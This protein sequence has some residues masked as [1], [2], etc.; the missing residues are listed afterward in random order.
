SLG[1]VTLATA[2]PQK[3]PQ[4]EAQLRALFKKWDLNNDGFLDREELA[5]HFRGPQAV[6]PAGG[7]YDDKG[8][9]TPLYHQ[10]RTK[11]PDLM[12]L[13]PLDKDLD[14]RVSWPEFEQYGLKYANALKQ[15][16]QAQQGLLQ[17]IYARANRNLRN[18]R[19]RRVHYNRHAPRSSGQQ[20][21]L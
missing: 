12:F 18:A 3:D 2:A 7:M 15:R 20:R 16:L 21:H 1:L 13:W 5:K 6:S 10:A 4:V 8:N 9:A 14:D 17:Q 11:Y 19:S